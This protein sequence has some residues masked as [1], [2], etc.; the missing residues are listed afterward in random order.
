MLPLHKLGIKNMGVAS[1]LVLDQIGFNV[2]LN[3]IKR[4]SRDLKPD[5]LLAETSLIGLITTIAA[6]ELS[7]PCFIDVHGLAFAEAK[8]AHYEK[9]IKILDLERDAFKNCSHLIVVSSKMKEYVSKEFKISQQKIT[10]APNGGEPRQIVAKYKRPIKVIYAG[11]FSYWEKVNDFLD[12]AKKADRKVF[13]FYLAGAGPMKDSLINR[14]REEKIP[15]NYLGYI[16][17]QQISGLLA[18]M[19]IGIAPSTKDLA[20]QV[21]SPI[22]IF[23]YMAV[24]LPVVTPKIGDWGSIIEKENC[25]I[26]LVDDNI[27]NYVAALD[28]LSEENIWNV[29]SKNGIKTI[30]EKYSWSK[31]LEPIATV[32]SVY[33]K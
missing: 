5:V 1:N 21:A 22:K 15:V 30:Q 10:V 4:L 23:D 3:R 20:R 13:E 8:G 2:S 28:T 12:L 26:S 29:K 25:G 19:Q 6:K 31:A 16:S 24:G 32:L 7:L 33:T 17:K 14:I 27:D 9:W 18:K 11:I